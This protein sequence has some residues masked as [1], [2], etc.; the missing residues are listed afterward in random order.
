MRTFVIG[1]EDCVL[2]FSLGNVGGQIV[3][4]A[5]QLEQALDSCLADKTI[6]LLLV[7]A[8]VACWRR[9]R[10][11]DL[12]VSSLT[13]LVVVIP[14]EQEETHYPSLQEFV[15]RAVGIRLGGN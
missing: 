13:P 9:A 3:R 1:N 10:I 2:G 5:E 7:T 15:Q 12:R 8:D 14:G 6:G 4:T 11:D